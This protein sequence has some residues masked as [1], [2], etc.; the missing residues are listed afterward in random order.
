MVPGHLALWLSSA[1]AMPQLSQLQFQGCC[2]PKTQSPMGLVSSLGTT[3]SEF[4]CLGPAPAPLGI[5]SLLAG[6]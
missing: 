2:S 6:Q 3:F 5:S 1:K 4:L